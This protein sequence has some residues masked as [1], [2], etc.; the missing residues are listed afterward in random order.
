VKHARQSR[1][2]RALVGATPCLPLLRNARGGVAGK[3]HI[4]FLR[5]PERS[6]PRPALLLNLLRIFQAIQWYTAAC[7]LVD[8]SFGLARAFRDV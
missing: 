8:E 6:P 4:T 7:G 5:L 3:L 1:R 2:Q